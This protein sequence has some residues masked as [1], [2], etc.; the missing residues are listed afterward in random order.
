MYISLYVKFGFKTKAADSERGERLAF[1]SWNLQSRRYPTQR[2]TPTTTHSKLAKATN[3]HTCGHSY[4]CVCCLTINK[5]AKRN[6]LRMW[7]NNTYRHTNEYVCMCVV[8]RNYQK[9]LLK[10]LPTFPQLQAT[11]TIF[12][13]LLL[14]ANF[15]VHTTEQSTVAAV[16][17][18]LTCT[19]H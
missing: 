17:S 16:Q 5:Q 9:P 12:A 19:I 13:T 7:I 6:K 18:A 3:L 15:L 11:T 1:K 4:V 8:K 2:D 14:S 10:D